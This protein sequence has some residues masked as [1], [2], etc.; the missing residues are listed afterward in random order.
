LY[1]TTFTAA[2]GRFGLVF[3][4]RASVASHFVAKIH[5]VSSKQWVVPLSSVG[6]FLGLGRNIL[7]IGR[8]ALKAIGLELSQERL[9]LGHVEKLFEDGDDVM[10]VVN[11]EGHP[12]VYPRYNVVIAAS[13]RIVEDPPELAREQVFD[14]V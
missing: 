5:L 3:L 10:A 13:L 7:R 1:G 9:E 11:L 14:E 8:N 4:F 12:I 6:I 2:G